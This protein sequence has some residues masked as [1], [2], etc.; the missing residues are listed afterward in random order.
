MMNLPM[1][2]I[3]KGKSLVLAKP[4]PLLIDFLLQIEILICLSLCAF[5][6]GGRDLSRPYC[7]FS[8]LWKSLKKET[9]IITS[10]TPTGKAAII[11]RP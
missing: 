2:Q 4:L 9:T 5:C 11:V 1:K 6:Q 7:S 3:F 8:H 10:R